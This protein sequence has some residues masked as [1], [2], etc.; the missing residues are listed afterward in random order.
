MSFWTQLETFACALEVEEQT[1]PFFPFNLHRDRM[2]VGFTLT[3]GAENFT[4]KPP[5]FGVMKRPAV[6]S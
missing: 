5:L 6:G 2:N 3:V 1:Q 4:P